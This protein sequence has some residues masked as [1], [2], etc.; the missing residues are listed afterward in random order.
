MRDAARYAEFVRGLRDD[1]DV[2]FLQPYLS[3]PGGGWSVRNRSTGGSTLASSIIPA[4]DRKARNRGLL[5]HD[6]L[7]PG[8][9]MLLAP[10]N[11]VHTWF[12]RF[13]IDVIFVGRTGRV[14]KIRR[15]V[16]PFRLA[17][18]LGAFAV[19]ELAAGSSS[20]TSVG[21]TLFLDR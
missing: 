1:G 19:I 2:S 5:G 4:F 10:C 17:F 9:A 20:H 21:D 7:R 8:V 3:R 15:A 16:A 14:L 18:R 6:S 12:M 13:P 11:G